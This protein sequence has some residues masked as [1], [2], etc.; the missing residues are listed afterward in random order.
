MN[1]TGHD[2]EA[3]IARPPY[4]YM[5]DTISRKLV[6]LV[7]TPETTF[8]VTVTMDLYWNTETKVDAAGQMN[9]N[10]RNNAMNY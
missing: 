1:L 4:T 9:A 7:V 2:T 5:I 6:K 3:E 8:F 10:N